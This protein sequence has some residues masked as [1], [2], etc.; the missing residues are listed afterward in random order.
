MKYKPNYG[1]TPEDMARGYTSGTKKPKTAKKLDER[2][3]NEMG[4]QPMPKPK[5]TKKD[6]GFLGRPKGDE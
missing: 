2:P 4:G 3:L 5:K 1:A 6:G